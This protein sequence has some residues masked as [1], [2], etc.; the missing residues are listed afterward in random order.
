MHWTLIALANRP[1]VVELRQLVDA[2]TTFQCPSNAAT[3][4]YA[5]LSIIRI[6]I[7]IVLVVLSSLRS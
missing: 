1:L 6:R 2:Q 5:Q 3:Y 7:V 4:S